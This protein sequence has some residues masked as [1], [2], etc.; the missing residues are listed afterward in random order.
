MGSG[1]AFVL[2]LVAVLVLAIGAAAYL[3][4]SALGLERRDSHASAADCE[5]KAGEDRSEL[6]D[7]AGSS[8]LTGAPAVAVTVSVTRPTHG[9]ASAAI[10][11]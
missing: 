6:G 8:H 3:V 11:A 4:A 5:A 10:N 7:G 1:Q 2:L 9:A